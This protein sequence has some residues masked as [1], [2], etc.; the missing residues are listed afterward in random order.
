MHSQKRT[1]VVL[2][3]EEPRGFLRE[4]H[5]IIPWYAHSGSSLAGLKH[6]H[7]R[8]GQEVWEGLPEKTGEYNR[9][10]MGMLPQ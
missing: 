8:L 4:V 2:S 1:A 3:S 9:L 10:S 6:R 7:R 5:W